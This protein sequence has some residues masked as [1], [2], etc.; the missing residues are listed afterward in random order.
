VGEE[1]AQPR[2][3]D[4]IAGDRVDI[5]ADLAGPSRLEPR[6]LRLQ[7]DV[8]G[9]RE[10]VRQLA[11]RERP[12]AVR[13]VA[14]DLRGG[15]DDDGLARLDRDVAR[16]RVRQRAVR[17]AG[18][19]RRESALLGAELAH[20]PLDHQASSVSVRPTK[21]SSA[22]RAKASFVIAAAG[23]SRRARPAP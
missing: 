5:S 20:R 15:V 6:E 10:L 4:D 3:G 22:S 23:G 13:V 2:V 7:A 11:R 12:R 1:L 21:R 9:A 14:V 17:P 18:D 8:V 19:D 16:A